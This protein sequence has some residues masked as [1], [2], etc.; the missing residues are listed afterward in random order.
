MHNLFFIVSFS[1]IILRKW[2]AKRV[3]DWEEVEEYVMIAEIEKD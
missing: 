1:S 2:K 3:D